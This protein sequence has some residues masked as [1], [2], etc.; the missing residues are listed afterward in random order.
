VVI[1]RAILAQH[2]GDRVLSERWSKTLLTAYGIP[3]S[4]ERVVQSRADA[5]DAAMEE[6]GFP[7]VLK[8]DS[9]DIAH[10]TEAGVVRL[11][12]R[13]AEAV[14]TA[15]DEIAVAAS[16]LTPPPRVDGVS[17]QEMVPAGLEMVV[18]MSQDPQLG[19]LMA[20]GLGGVLVELL[21]DAQVG[22]APLGLPEAMA[23]I[24]R[25]RGRKLLD[26]FRGAPRVDPAMLADIL[27]RVS[28][29]ADD[30]KHEIAEI[31]VNPVILLPD[32]AVAVD[33]LIVPKRKE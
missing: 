9:P 26:G 17:V 32:R 12:L 10:K 1:A 16:R 8:I 19:P 13:D 23:M 6:V 22:L 30:L 25:L 5:I 29:L 20:V 28:E 27:V 3:V 21:R 31:D 2:A 24:D 11:N 33:A 15:Y 14:G 18:G 4:R 7:C